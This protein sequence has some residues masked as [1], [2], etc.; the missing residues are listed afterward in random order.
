MRRLHH[1]TT[2]Q[3][4]TAAVQVVVVLLGVV[5]VIVLVVVVGVVVV[6]VGCDGRHRRVVKSWVTELG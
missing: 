3:H 5:G 2:F 1:Y 6:V 4:S